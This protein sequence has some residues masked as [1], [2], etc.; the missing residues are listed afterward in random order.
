M[1]LIYSAPSITW[2]WIVVVTVHNSVAAHADEPLRAYKDTAFTEQFRRSSGWIAGDGALSVPLSDGRV[3]WL[4]GDSHLDDIDPANG[5]MACLFQC[6]NV[7][8][9]QGPANTLTTNDLAH[10][11]TLAG[12]GPGFRSWFKNSTNDWF[13]FWPVCG[14]QNRDLVYVYLAAFT[15]SG[16]GGMFDFESTGHDCWGK[17]KF[18][19]L[20]I[21]G[22]SELPSFNGITFGTGFVQEADYTY[23]FGGKG[24]GLAGDLYVA[25]FTTAHPER[26]WRFWNGLR[27]ESNVTNAVAVA[28]GASTSLHVCK[29]R[30]RFLLT[31]SAW[32]VACDQGKD[33]FM[34]TSPDATGPFSKLKKVFTIDDTVDGHYPF[35][36]F[37][38][39]H[40][41]FTNSKDELLVTY[42]I[43]CYEPCI[44][45]CKDGRAIPDHYRPQAIRV[46]LRMIDSKW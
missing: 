27:W 46:P 1:N 24:R 28:R 30:D 32:S 6:R 39:A 17:L 18:P 4:F 12:H 45:S 16:K 9:V 40:P 22:Y 34:A 41:E 25:R 2:L 36:Y 33:I 15:R 14:F 37:P 31:T 13:W 10:A 19:S 7:G 43:N 3:L 42:S 38:V 29:V 5:T 11:R 8:L 21:V 35:F 26:G 44:P 23:A 20:E